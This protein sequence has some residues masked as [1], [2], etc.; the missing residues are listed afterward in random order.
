MD[1]VLTSLLCSIP[2]VLCMSV[3]F[4]LPGILY[5]FFGFKL[6]S[7]FINFFKGNSSGQ[8][9]T[10]NYSF[11]SSS[12]QQSAYQQTNSSEGYV[13]GRYSSRDDEVDYSNIGNA[14]NDYNDYHSSGNDEEKDSGSIIGSVLDFFD[15]GTTY[16]RDDDD[17]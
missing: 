12:S 9:V 13:V 11:N 8:V 7:S 4:C 15:I 1:E 17:E 3:A 6:I 10:K 14:S 2:T 5:W 16:G